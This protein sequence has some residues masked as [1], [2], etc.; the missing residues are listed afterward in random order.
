MPTIKARLIKAA[1]V[2]KTYRDNHPDYKG[3]PQ[4]PDRQAM[5]DMFADCFHLAEKNGW[6]PKQMIQTAIGH[7]DTETTVYN[8]PKKEA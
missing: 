1:R 4:E 7:F 5:I 2:L 8:T 3:S 6:K